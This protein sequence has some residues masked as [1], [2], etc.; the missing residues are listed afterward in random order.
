MSKSD[1]EE[2]NYTRTSEFDIIIR[3]HKDDSQRTNYW[4]TNSFRLSW[5]SMKYTEEDL[6]YIN[7]HTICRDDTWR[8]EAYKP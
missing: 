6:K 1:C 7:E 4:D 5:I 8:V 3:C 2:I